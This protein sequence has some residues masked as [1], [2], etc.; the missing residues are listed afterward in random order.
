MKMKIITMAT[1]ALPQAA[2][3]CQRRIQAKQGNHGKAQG[4]LLTRVTS[5]GETL[6]K[7]SKHGENNSHDSQSAEKEESTSEPV[8]GEHVEHT[9][10]QQRDL[11][12]NPHD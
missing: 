11:E 6:R 3:N 2:S 5:A 7:G 10:D 12:H 9:S 8:D 1:P 4:G